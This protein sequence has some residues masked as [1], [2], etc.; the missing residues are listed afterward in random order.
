MKEQETI[1]KLID[2][3][4]NEI[5]WI[6][7]F[8]IV[9]KQTDNRRADSFISMIS[10]FEKMFGD[11]FWNN[12]ILEASFWS[13]ETNHKARRLQS[14]PPITRDFWSK[15][16]NK[17]LIEK[18]NIQKPLQSVFIDSYVNKNN[19]IE[20]ENFERETETLWNFARLR[21]PFHCKDIN[22][23]LTEIQQLQRELEEAHSNTMKDRAELARVSSERDWYK[24]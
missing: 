22:I 23:A 1:E 5:Q 7:A 9:F 16:Y 15:Q 10:L 11:H 24:K 20:V 13:F 17:N 18:F 2:V 21:E 19:P 12:A 14:Q 3:L 8:V 4:K 6:H